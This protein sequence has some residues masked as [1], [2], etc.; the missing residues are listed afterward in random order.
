[1]KKLL[2]LLM[3][4]LMMVC[5]V[6]CGSGEGKDNSSTDTKGSN[7]GSTAVT[8]DEEDDEVEVKEKIALD[9]R[10]PYV[11]CVKIG[12]TL[13]IN[14]IE[15]IDGLRIGVTWEGDGQKIAKYYS[16]DPEKVVGYGGENDAFSELE[17]GTDLD[18]V[19]VKQMAGKQYQDRGRS[20]IILDPIV[21]PEEDLAK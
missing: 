19:I 7:D 6:A 2:A 10:D 11:V 5:L 8:P 18:C 9:G 13:E 12:S 14:S 4:I 3:A 1:M 16:T 21:I 15:D 20:F 17:G